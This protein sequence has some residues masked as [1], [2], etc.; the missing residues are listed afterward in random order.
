MTDLALVLEHAGRPDVVAHLSNSDPKRV[1]PLLAKKRLD[2]ADLA[3]LLSPGAAPLLEDMARR[4]AAITRSRFGN[5]VVLYAPLYISNHCSGNCPYCGFKNTMNIR[6]VTLSLD[7]IRKEAA[8]LRDA[9]IRHLLLVSG[10]G[11]GTETDDLCAIARELKPLFPSISVEVP[12]LSQPD[13]ARLLSSGV[14]GVTLYQ[15]TYDRCRYHRLHAD[16]PKEDFDFR[17]DALSRAGAA[18]MRRLNIGALWGL[19]DWR[20]DALSLGLHARFL[21]KECWRS[22]VLIG[23][24]RLHQVPGDFAIPHPVCDRDFVHIIVALRLFC[25]DAGIV[26]STRERPEFRDNLLALGATQFSAGSKTHPGGYAGDVDGGSQ[27]DID[28]CRSA[29][30]VQDALSQKGYDPVLKDWDAGFLC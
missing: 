3:L 28:D 23:M 9:G 15:E 13:Y 5:A 20:A 26:V 24:P 11:P 17:L 8:V 2:I 27:F 25:H 7:Q 19:S 22:Q 4:A 16:G 18:G 6:R 1:V 14:D 30:A 12:P 10:D 29:A 21:E